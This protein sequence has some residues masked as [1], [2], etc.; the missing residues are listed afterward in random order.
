MHMLMCTFNET[1]VVSKTSMFMLFFFLDNMHWPSMS[2][3][4]YVSSRS[5]IEVRICNLIDKTLMKRNC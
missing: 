4:N 5:I 3:K 1:G 2:L